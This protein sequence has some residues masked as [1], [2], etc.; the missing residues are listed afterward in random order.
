M[1]FHDP[2]HIFLWI[3]YVFAQLGNY[4]ASLKQV[5]VFF[6]WDLF[7][8]VGFGNELIGGMGLK[9]SMLKLPL[10]SFYDWINPIVQKII[11]Y[12]RKQSSGLYSKN[13]LNCWIDIFYD[14]KTS[15]ENRIIFI[16]MN[17]NQKFWTLIKSVWCS[18]N[19]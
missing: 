13:K 3:T 17:L 4:F 6:F 18:L 9:T 11:L 5:R 7:F 2:V 10:F 8:F 12:S 14:L 15:R 16:F 19:N 1:F